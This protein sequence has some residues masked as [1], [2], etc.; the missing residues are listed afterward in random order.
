MRLGL[1]GNVKTL[2]VLLVHWLLVVWV[3][4][5]LTW[6]RALVV[7]VDICIVIVYHYNLPT[8]C[9]VLLALHV[10]LL[11]KEL[12]NIALVDQWILLR[13]YSPVVIVALSSAVSVILTILNVLH[14]LVLR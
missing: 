10:L 4:R 1:C 6:V 8:V 7:N 11:I 3:L 2:S 9:Q 5:V 13:K 12:V 14:L